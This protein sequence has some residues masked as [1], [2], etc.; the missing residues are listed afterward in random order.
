MFGSLQP[1]STGQWIL[2]SFIGK[3]KLLS[4]ETGRDKL[5]RMRAFAHHSRVHAKCKFDLESSCCF[6]EFFGGA[7]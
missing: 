5:P 7:E 3:T 2:A 1:V 4:G 6:I